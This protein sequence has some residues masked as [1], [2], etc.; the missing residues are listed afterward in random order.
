MHIYICQA[1][2]PPIFTEEQ[3]PI[4]LRLY[5]FNFFDIKML[6]LYVMISI[7][8]DSCQS[9]EKLKIDSL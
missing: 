1:R 9:V 4:I 2:L 5:P 7:V 6:F 3:L 8:N